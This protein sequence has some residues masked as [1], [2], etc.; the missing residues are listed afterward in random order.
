[1]LQGDVLEQLKKLPEGCIQTCVCS[2]PYYALRSYLPTDHPDKAKEVGIEKTPTEYV[3]RLVEVFAEVRRVL[4][5]DGT[6]WLNLGDSYANDGKWGGKTGGKH[7]KDLHGATDIGRAKKRTGLKPKDLIGIPW[8]VA[9][10]LREEGWWLRSEVIWAKG[11]PMPEAVQDRPTRAHETVFLLTKSQDYFY[12]SDAI[13]EPV[14]NW[15]DGDPRYQPGA[16]EQERNLEE[17]SRHAT[18]GKPVTGLSRKPVTSRNKRDVWTLNNKPYKGAHFATM[19]EELARLCIL[20]GSSERGS[21]PTC[22]APWER[23]IERGESHYAELKGDRHWTDLQDDAKEM[24]WTTRGGPTLTENGT[25]PSLHAAQRVE[26]GWQATCECLGANGAVL[27][28]IPCLI[29]DPF[30]GSGTTLAVAKLLGRDY[31]GV[32]LNEAYLPLIAERVRKPTEWQ[33]EHSIFEAM[34][35]GGD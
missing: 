19:P 22:G 4:R 7:A 33:E 11:N 25:M 27:E 8:A 34:M 13:R 32:E 28:P 2:P 1:M 14:G 35:S 21:C 23:V 10:A 16:E 24:G 12:D 20:A 18:P 26:K 15:V 3:S 31:V 30:A 5:P 17:P 6:L 9:F 29:L